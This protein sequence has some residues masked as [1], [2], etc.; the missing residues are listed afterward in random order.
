MKC[1]ALL[2]L[3]A[4]SGYGQGMRDEI[5]AQERAGLEALKIGDI[6]A[7]GDSM[8]EDAVFVDSSGPAGKAQVVK[9]VSGFKLRDFAMTDVRFVTLSTDT[10]L[11]VYTLEESGSTHG[12]EFSAR[13]HVASVWSK[14]SGKW[15]CEF[16][17]ETAAKPVAK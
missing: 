1:S 2:I 11:I 6:A 12:K 15:L 16:S 13:V 17:Q 4:I 10:G 14:H 7:F 3:F 8:A 5:V 9:N